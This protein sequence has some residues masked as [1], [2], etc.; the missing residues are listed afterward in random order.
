VSIIDTIRRHRTYRAQMRE[1]R[2]VQSLPELGTFVGQYVTGYRLAFP[3]HGFAS[4]P[5]PDPE[6]REIA[7]HLAWLNRRGLVTITSQPA[8]WS[9]DPARLHGC[10]AAAQRAGV[11][12]LAPPA[13]ADEI[14]R[15]VERAGLRGTATL[16]SA[17]G[18]R[19]ARAAEQWIPVT[20]YTCDPVADDDVSDIDYVGD[21]EGV[22]WRVATGFGGASR[23]GLD[24][25]TGAVGDGG[26]DAIEA[27]SL[28]T[29]VDPEWGRHDELWAVLTG[30]VL[31]ARTA[32][33]R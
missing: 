5:G 31:G 20:V 30:A 11:E 14:V 33:V 8:F 10:T 29:V 4:Q 13:L 26:A 25:L 27:A 18:T 6:T 7:H 12:F 16:V 1:Y 17:L 28:V 3:G 9:A 32:G 2:S 23:H 15:R 24:Y 21:F 22:T 19:R